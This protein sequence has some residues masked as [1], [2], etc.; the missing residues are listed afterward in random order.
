MADDP[1]C[2]FHQMICRGPVAVTIEQAADDSAIQNT[3]ERIVFR[4]G[5]PFRNDF[6]IPDE[7]P[8]VQAFAI[9]W[10]AAEARVFGSILVLK[11]LFHCSVAL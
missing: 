2:V 6:A 3:R 1:P 10:A 7:T 9:R 4:L 5:L 8:H 11:R